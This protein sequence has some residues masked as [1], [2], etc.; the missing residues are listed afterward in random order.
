MKSARIALHLVT[1][2][3]LTSS[4]LQGCSPENEERSHDI[5]ER[6]SHSATAG[7][8]GYSGKEGISRTINAGDVRFVLVVSREACQCTLK[9]CREN[10][11]Y[12]EET[13]EKLG[14]GSNLNVL[15]QANE[16]DNTA[17]LIKRYEIRFIPSLL[18]LDSEGK[19]LHRCDWDIDRAGFE[20]F[21]SQLGSAE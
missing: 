7:H 1:A 21:L 20:E 2:A 13:L 17:P 6:S 9:R 15:D 4:M 3:L 18:V 5:V 16:E 14:L 19:V 8:E 10:R 11:Q 12:L